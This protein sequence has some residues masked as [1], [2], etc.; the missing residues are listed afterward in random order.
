V[1]VRG[2][3]VAEDREGALYLTP[4]ASRGTRIMDCCS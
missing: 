1:A 2:L 3:V 4:G